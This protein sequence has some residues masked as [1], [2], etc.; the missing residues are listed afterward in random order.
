MYVVEKDLTRNT[1]TVA[2]K[3]PEQKINKKLKLI[4]TNFVH[5]LDQIDL[6]NL[7]IRIR[8]RA[9]FLMGKLAITSKNDAEIEIPDLT[10][11]VASGQSVVLYSDGECIG[12]GIVF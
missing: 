12:G 4:N 2:D 9:N 11:N 5:S 6:N 1:I 8:Y 3:M 7:D 10:E